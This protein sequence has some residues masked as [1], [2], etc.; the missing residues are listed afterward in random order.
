MSLV[1]VRFGG[2]KILYGPRYVHYRLHRK[3]VLYFPISVVD[4]LKDHDAPPALLSHRLIFLSLSHTWTCGRVFV[5]ASSLFRRILQRVRSAATPR[6][7][8]PN[9]LAAV[10]L[11]VCPESCML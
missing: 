9:S 6:Y 2:R 4:I 10:F 3:R 7:V 8:A 11:T 1:S 5:P